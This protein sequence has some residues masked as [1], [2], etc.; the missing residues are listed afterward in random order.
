MAKILTWCGGL[1]IALSVAVCAIAL[2]VR[3]E[4][5]G[6]FERACDFYVTDFE[7]S[8]RGMSVE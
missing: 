2:L 5:F 8:R 1:P 3:Q 6:N 7:S 4:L